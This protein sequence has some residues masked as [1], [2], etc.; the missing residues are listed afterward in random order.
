MLLSGCWCWGKGFA[1]NDCPFTFTSFST[2]WPYNF[3]LSRTRNLFAG[4][5]E[6]VFAHRITSQNLLPIALSLL[7]HIWEV[8]VI[9]PNSLK[10]GG[11]TI[12][13]GEKNNL[14]SNRDRFGEISFMEQK[15]II[16]SSLPEDKKQET[17]LH[18]I[19][20]ALNGY[21]SLDLDHEVITTLGFG[22]YQVLKDNKLHF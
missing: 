13:V 16:D 14:S 7:Y 21:F 10:I 12:K 1:P 15:I 2:P 4:F 18:E 3:S 20:E 6:L 8:I 11:L 19:I 22:L 9:I 17:L 5:I